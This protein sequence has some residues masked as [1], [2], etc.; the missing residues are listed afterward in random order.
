MG[1]L[2]RFLC[3][4]FALALLVTGCVGHRE[5]L[6]ALERQAT[7]INAVES[8]LA[9]VDERT[10]DVTMQ[11]TCRMPEFGHLLLCSL[12]EANPEGWKISGSW[13]GTQLPLPATSMQSIRL[14]R[15]GIPPLV[16]GPASDEAGASGW[17]RVSQTRRAL[18]YG[19]HRLLRYFSRLV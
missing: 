13:R 18:G 5:L 14:T 4:G 9:R 16:V 17:Q 2:S 15:E 1:C 11:P 3:V 7:R 8:G 6:A 10:K 12:A 19:A